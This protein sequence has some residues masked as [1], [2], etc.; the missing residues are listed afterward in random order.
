MAYD[1]SSF[2]L[3]SV[4][5]DGQ[6]LK[7]ENGVYKNAGDDAEIHSLPFKL[8]LAKTDSDNLCFEV[9]GGAKFGGHVQ[10]SGSSTLDIDQ[11]AYFGADIELDKGSAQ[12]I[13]HQTQDLTI[14][15][16]GSGKKLKLFGAAQVEVEDWVF[17]DYAITLADDASITAAAGK[18]L[19]LQAGSK[20]VVEDLEFNG[21]GLT[22]ASEDAVITAATGKKIDVV[23]KAASSWS[24]DSGSLTVEGKD[25]LVLQS[26]DEDVKIFAATQAKKILIGDSDSAA[27]GIDANAITDVTDLT[28]KAGG[29]LT[30][31]AAGGQ[32]MI[33]KAGSSSVAAVL[34]I[35]SDGNSTFAGD[36]VIQGNLTVNGGTT[37]INA[38]TL[39]VDDKNIELA[40]TNSPSDTSAN[41]GGITLKGTNDYTI[42]W[43]SSS[44]QWHYNKGISVDDGGSSSPNKLV[45][46]DGLDADDS[47]STAVASVELTG[48]LLVGKRIIQSDATD[49]S[50]SAA[51]LKTAGGLL[52][53]KKS[54]LTAGVTIAAVS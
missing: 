2:S 17:A 7:I 22:F 45:V 39:T 27:I 9:A 35:G 24:T 5:H 49:A 19:S 16:I 14:Q 20:V 30:V 37:T 36:A 4:T 28:A 23:A 32:S 33:F 42:S 15:A 6:L 25:A 53:G 51:A 54:Y 1:S 50:S 3:G 46:L 41:G 26:A 38:T 43:S 47:S 44:G 13:Q 10:F 31:N 40:S 18:Q 8:K 29:A 12:V 11:S 21:G 34:T 48:G 52:V